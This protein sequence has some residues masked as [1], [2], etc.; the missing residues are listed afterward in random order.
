EPDVLHVLL[1]VP[2]RAA[3]L[4]A[5]PGDAVPDLEAALQR[6]LDRARER[7]VAADIDR[8]AGTDHARALRDPGIVPLRLRV[9]RGIGEDEVRLGARAQSLEGVA[10]VDVVGKGAGRD[11][12]D[13][14]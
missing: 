11:R 4:L 14:D 2:L 9:V 7:P 1:P 12:R 5:P 13:I 6:R 3:T 10:A 8:P